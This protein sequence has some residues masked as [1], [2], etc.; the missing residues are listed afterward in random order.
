MATES[1]RRGDRPAQ[2]PS[3]SRLPSATD[4]GFRPRVSALGLGDVSPTEGLEDFAASPDRIH[5]VAMSP[6]SRLGGG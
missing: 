1:E 3:G 2:P 4:P 5:P 6:W